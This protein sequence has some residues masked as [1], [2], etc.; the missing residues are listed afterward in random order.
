MRTA[1]TGRGSIPRFY[2]HRSKYT[3]HSTLC[4][5]R[6]HAGEVWIHVALFIDALSAMYP[7]VKPVVWRSD[8]IPEVGL[9]DRFHL[10]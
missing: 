1:A 4:R 2:C 6:H 3:W 9:D 7:G 5:R 8:A 10:L